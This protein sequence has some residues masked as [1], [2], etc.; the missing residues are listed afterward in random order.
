MGSLLETTMKRGLPSGEEEEES[1]GD[2]VGDGGPGRERRGWW[3]LGRRGEMTSPR[4]FS[5]AD[6]FSVFDLLE[7]REEVRTRMY[8]LRRS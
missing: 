8:A 5:G 1:V 7:E 2:M 4:V 6:R 3:W